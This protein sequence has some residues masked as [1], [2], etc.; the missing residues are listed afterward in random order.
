MF[1]R[2]YK[3]LVEQYVLCTYSVYSLERLTEQY[4]AS[5]NI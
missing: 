3:N 5:Y 4:A 2:F 1:L